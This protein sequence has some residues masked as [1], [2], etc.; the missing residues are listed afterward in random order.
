LWYAEIKPVE[1]IS[2]EKG[3]LVWEKYSTDTFRKI[4][5]VFESQ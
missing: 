3:D 2:D 5:Q 4:K 1:V